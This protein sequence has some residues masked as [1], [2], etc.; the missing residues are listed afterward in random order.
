MIKIILGEI[1][2]FR[3]G[4]LL[5]AILKAGKMAMQDLGQSNMS[6]AVSISDGIRGESSGLTPE[7]DNRDTLSDS[8]RN[9]MRSYILRDEERC[10]AA[11][12][13]FLQ[14]Q[15]DQQVKHPPV[16]QRGCSR[17]LEASTPILV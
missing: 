13:R 4:K 6:T 15:L 1:F 3:R 8:H 7:A 14:Q 12:E 11:Q 17:L 16:N 2:N 5:K 9:F 10:R